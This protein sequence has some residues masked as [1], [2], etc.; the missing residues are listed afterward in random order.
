MHRL[1]GSIVVGVG[2]KNM[3]SKKIYHYIFPDSIPEA[4]HKL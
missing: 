3:Y 4:F 1:K 2:R